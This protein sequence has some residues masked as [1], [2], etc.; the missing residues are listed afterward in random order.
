MHMHKHIHITF[1]VYF[2][3]CVYMISGWTNHFVL[4][5]HLGA[6]SWKWFSLSQRLLAAYSSVSGLAY[7]EISSS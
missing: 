6:P 5:N 2:C 7:P 3:C 1:C 4:D